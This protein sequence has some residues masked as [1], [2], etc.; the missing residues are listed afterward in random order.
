VYLVDTSVWVEFLRRSG[1][2]AIQTQLR[3]L[4]LNGDVALTEWIVLELMTGLRASEKPGVLLEGLA[5]V[6]RL[7]FPEDGWRAAWN[8]AAGLR[9]RGVTPSAADC[10]IATVAIAAEVTLIHCDG[11]FEAIANQSALRTI[12]WTAHLS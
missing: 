2:R 7:S 8:L 12:D 5:A 9:K 1:S 4:V 3:P 11:D 6:H 10:Y